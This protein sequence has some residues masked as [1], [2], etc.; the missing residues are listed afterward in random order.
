MT[1]HYS[2]RAQ[3]LAT[4]YQR[5]GLTLPT[6]GIVADVRAVQ[7][8]S[9]KEWSPAFEATVTCAT[10]PDLLGKVNAGPVV[11]AYR[12]LTLR[13][14]RLLRHGVAVRDL[15]SRWAGNTAAHTAGYG[16][17]LATLD[18]IVQGPLDADLA[19]EQILELA[20]MVREIVPNDDG[21]TTVQLTSA[22]MVLHDIRRLIAED[23]MGT[24]QPIPIGDVDNAAQIQVFLDA[25]GAQLGLPFGTVQLVGSTPLNADGGSSIAA[26][27]ML[28]VG[29]TAADCIFDT[30]RCKIWAE[31]PTRYRAAMPDIHRVVGPA[32]VDAFGRKVGLHVLVAAPTYRPNVI[33]N[34]AGLYMV[35]DPINNLRGV[36][37]YRFGSS[38][39]GLHGLRVGFVDTV[40]GRVVPPSNSHPDYGKEYTT[41]ARYES[42]DKRPALAEVQLTALADFDV[43]AGQQL[44]PDLFDDVAGPGAPEATAGTARQI[45]WLYPEGTMTITADL[46]AN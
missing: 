46:T 5:D 22:E 13:L 33:G 12:Y 40:A 2:F 31:S 21:T 24:P 38:V 9:S 30:M 37:Q 35:A 23:D 39:E 14:E 20:M 4:S 3:L 28:E 44:H 45:V 15:T 11:N 6:S 29:Q 42:T 8:T 10:T 25:A 36:V 7:L 32:A 27:A 34:Q 43:R 16:G 17:N 18:G 26:G 1:D 19:G 41:V